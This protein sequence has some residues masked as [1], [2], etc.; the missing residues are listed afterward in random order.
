MTDFV[1]MLKHDRD[2]RVSK[3]AN[4]TEEISTECE[5]DLSGLLQL[6]FEKVSADL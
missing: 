3:I 4:V 1:N 5:S 2:S 6:S